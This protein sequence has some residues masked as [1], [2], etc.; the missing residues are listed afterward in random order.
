MCGM[1]IFAINEALLRLLTGSPTGA[2]LD[3]FVN[4][5]THNQYFET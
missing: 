3:A 5:P 4:Q 1:I 2:S